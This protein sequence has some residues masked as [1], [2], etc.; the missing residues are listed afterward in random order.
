MTT[1][2]PQTASEVETPFPAGSGDDKVPVSVSAMD[3]HSGGR[4]DGESI[5]PG[6]SVDPAGS[7]TETVDQGELEER[8]RKFTG[9]DQ[10][11]ERQQ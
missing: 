7:A 4:V 3:P 10:Q 11:N 1:P 6:D 2:D 8:I 5:T 9:K